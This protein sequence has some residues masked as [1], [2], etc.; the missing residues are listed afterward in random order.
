MLMKGSR[1]ELDPQGDTILVLRCPKIEQPVWEPKDEEAKRKERSRILRLKLF[2]SEL[3]PDEEKTQEPKPGLDAPAN[4]SNVPNDSREA[5]GENSERNEVLFR[6]S[7]RHLALASPVFQTM[8]NGSWKESAPSSDPFDAFDET[9]APLRD[10]TDCPVRY[11]LTV[12][13]WNEEV[14]LLLTNILHCRNAVVPLS[15]DLTT[16]VKMSV[17][18]DYYQCQEATQLAASLWIGKLSGNLP[19]KDDTSAVST[20]AVV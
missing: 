9:G 4:P 2:G 8:L 12:T 16:L 15:S 7:S 10:G 1:F 5:H 20:F 13:E 3:L 6:L 14:F 17:L 18:V 11:E 19:T